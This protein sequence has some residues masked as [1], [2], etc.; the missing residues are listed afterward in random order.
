M[1]LVRNPRKDKNEKILDSDK[2]YEEKTAESY[3]DTP[4]GGLGAES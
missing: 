2:N 3:H 4:G 1:L